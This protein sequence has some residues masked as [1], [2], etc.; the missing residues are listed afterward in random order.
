MPGITKQELESLVVRRE[1]PCVSI[2]MPTERA[3][4]DTKQNPIRLKNLIGQAAD[5]LEQAGVRS[6]ESQAIL[7]DATALLADT[8]FWQ[9]Q[10]DG[11]ALFMAPGFFL[12]FRQPLP[13]SELALVGPRFHVKP[14]LPL[15]SSHGRFYLV[16]LSQHEVRVFRGTTYGVDELQIADV[17]ESLADA[18]KFDEFEA[19]LQYHT[20]TAGQ[21]L[22]GRRPAIFHGHGAGGDIEHDSIL[23]YFRKVDQGLSEV[24]DGAPLVLAGVEY[25]HPIY[26]AANT[27]ANLVPEGVRGNPESM[28]ASELHSLAWPI[29]RARL[30]AE[31][32]TAVERF[33]GQ[34]G[35]GIASEDV[36][37]T[38]RAAA[39]GRVDLLFVDVTGHAWGVLDRDTLEVH[40]EDGPSPENADLLDQAAVHTLRNGGK[41]YA[42]PPHEMPVQAPVAAVF[43]Y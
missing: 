42:L 18:L 4:G 7:R 9:R 28:S 11:L 31:R 3:G 19:E 32:A 38:V 13:F 43:R 12:G 5:G 41:V 26:A 36:A 34:I 37:E 40:A 17:P 27:Y 30:E 16:A 29:V 33:L 35:T 22:H 10:S 15:L 24:L 2:Y 25:L 8:L 39:E 21:G 14:L 1:G 20:A 6:L 23:R